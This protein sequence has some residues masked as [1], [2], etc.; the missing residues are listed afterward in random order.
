MEIMRGIIY[1][2]DELISYGFSWNEYTSV[3]TRLICS[4]LPSPDGEWIRNLLLLLF[5]KYSLMLHPTP[6]LWLILMVVCWNKTLHNTCL[7]ADS[8]KPLLSGISVCWYLDIRRSVGDSK[9]KGKAVLCCG[10]VVGR[11]VNY[12]DKF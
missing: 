4:P 11:W 1:I 9:T 3:C 8:D 6:I 7:E 2:L 12:N 10:C 5:M